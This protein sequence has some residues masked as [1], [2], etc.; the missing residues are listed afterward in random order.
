MVRIKQIRIP[1]TAMFP[2]R[3]PYRAVVSSLFLNHNPS[4][5]N[6]TPGILFQSSSHPRGR[7]LRDL[8]YRFKP[9]RKGAETHPAFYQN[10]QVPHVRIIADTRK[11]KRLKPLFHRSGTV[12]FDAKIHVLSRRSLQSLSTSPLRPTLWLG[13]M[14]VALVDSY[15]CD[16]AL[17]ILRLMQLRN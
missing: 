8:P 5:R 12:E 3:E 10:Y 6:E 7:I 11:T 14:L 16:R 17:E 15:T 13:L 1:P 2:S 4:K 9:L